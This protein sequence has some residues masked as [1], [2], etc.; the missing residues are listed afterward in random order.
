[1]CSSDLPD[2]Y[3]LSQ[4]Y[5]N[6][7]NPVTKITFAIP[8]RGL[9]SLKVYD[10]L[11]RVTAELVNEIK[12]AGNYLIDFDASGFAS[13]VYFYKLEVNGFS[14]VKRMIIIK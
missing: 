13:G 2:K 11:G 1:V 14:D 7:F 8:K 5:P 9:V 3:I 10:V 4:N 12:T 6:P